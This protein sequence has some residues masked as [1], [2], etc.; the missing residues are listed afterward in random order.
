ML[1]DLLE[2]AYREKNEKFVE[3]VECYAPGK[4][5]D[6]IKEMIL[7][8]YEAAMSH[9]FPEEWL[10]QC[11]EVYRAD[12]V[13]KLREEEWM[14]L[15]W[16]TVDEELAQ[17]E[18]LVRE[19]AAVCREPGGPYLYEEALD[20]DLLSISAARRAAEERD[21]DKMAEFLESLSFARLPGKKQPEAEETKKE[22]VKSLREEEKNILKELSSRYFCW[23]E[24]SLL[25]LLSCCR[26]PM[27]S[28]V[29]DAFLS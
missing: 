1:K 17:A 26:K 10:N 19:G 20:S 13:E 15:L 3:L 16:E 6:E 7:K 8:L 28:L 5:D 12:S 22:L 9:P 23:R 18:E 27:E 4:T 2:D 24:E 11:L 29:D 25:A 14:K 21:Y